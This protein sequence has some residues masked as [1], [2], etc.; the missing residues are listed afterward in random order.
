MD[1]TKIIMAL[2]IALLL[3]IA[4]AALKAWYGERN[5]PV[6]SQIEYVNVPE[7]REV[8]KIK[9]VRVPGP[10]EIV[11]IEKEKIVEKLRLPNWFAQNA[12]EQV[13]ATAEIQP[14]EGITDTVATLNTKTG[15]GN[16]IAKQRPLSLF[17]FENNK[18]IGAR[19]GYTTDE[20]KQLI[21]VFGRWQFFRV[22]NVHAGLYAEGNSSG[23]AVGQLELNYRW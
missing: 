20:F 16:I 14:Y 7:I 22:G 10:T 6:V 5:K 3:L 12:D 9:K 15:A 17:A 19:A 8:V 4:I 23:E 13:I 11:T 21:T 2:I 1:K 18:E